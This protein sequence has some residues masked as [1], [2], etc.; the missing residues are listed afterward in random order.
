MIKPKLKLIIIGLIIVFS[1][2]SQGSAGK[3][4]QKVSKNSLEPISKSVFVYSLSFPQAK[5]VGNP[6]ENKSRKLSGR[7][8]R[9]DRLKAYHKISILR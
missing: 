1:N 3:V 2:G 4:S 5:R 8:S 7:T 6:S 9:N